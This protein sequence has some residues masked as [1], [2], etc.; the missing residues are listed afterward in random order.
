MLPV[1]VSNCCFGQEDS[2]KFTPRSIERVQLS[3]GTRQLNEI[4]TNLSDWNKLAP[5][6]KFLN[7]D[8]S[9]YDQG[10]GYGI[11]E[12][13]IANVNLY[14][15]P[16]GKRDE[17]KGSGCFRFGCSLTTSDLF[18]YFLSSSSI[19]RIDTLTSSNSGLEIYMDSVQE[20]RFNMSYSSSS[21]QGELAYLYRTKESARWGFF[22]GVGVSIGFSFNNVV[23]IS[24]SVESFEIFNFSTGGYYAGNYGSYNIYNFQNE[25]FRLK[26][27]V[28]CAAYLPLGVTFRVGKKNAFLRKLQVSYEFRPG[29]EV[30]QIPELETIV[31][32][33]GYSQL[34]IM[35]KIN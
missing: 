12:D 27:G 14:I 28:V 10:V 3:V 25:S 17:T 6:S 23:S 16:H 15:S 21:L 4:P 29:I 7:Q 22:G 1:F 33:Y 24:K 31:N 19:T 35:V 5:K 34:G 18:S 13:V 26:S 11:T 30:R 32:S 2:L 8:F 9:G 20:N